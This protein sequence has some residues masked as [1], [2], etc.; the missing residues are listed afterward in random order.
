M[1]FSKSVAAQLPGDSSLQAKIALKVAGYIATKCDLPE[2][3]KINLYLQI[4]NSH[5]AYKKCRGNRSADILTCRQIIDSLG[6]KIYKNF[7]NKAYKAYLEFTTSKCWLPPRHPQKNK[8][9]RLLHQR[10]FQYLVHR[11]YEVKFYSF[12]KI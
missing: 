4:K 12:D 8:R 3:V 10:Q 2:Q 7:G 9:S 1:A 11:F 5:E 6:A